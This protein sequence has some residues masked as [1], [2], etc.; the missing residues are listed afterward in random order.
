VSIYVTT[1]VWKFSRSSGSSLLTALAIADF[2]DDDGRA[3]PSIATLARKSRVSERTVQYAL[4][5]LRGLGELEIEANTG[6]KGTNTYI[7]LVDV[8]R[9]GANPAGGAN[10]AGVQNTTAGG[11][12]G[13]TQ[14][15][16]ENRQ[17][18]KPPTP[19]V[20]LRQDGS[21]GLYRLVVPQE[22]FDSYVKAYPGVDVGSEIARAEAWVN[23]NLR[24]RPTSSFGRFL[25]SWLNRAYQDAKERARSPSLRVVGGKATG[26]Q[27]DR[28]RMNAWL[29]G[30]QDNTQPEEQSNVVDV[31]ATEVREG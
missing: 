10:S 13:C 3:Y 7:V 22:V 4:D 14:T 2:A 11:A 28:D 29:F 26:K 16:I 21:S 31:V 17:K 19:K 1:L 12:T 27:A 9:R 5:D 18:K 24:R 15:V 23:D 8:L 25:N 6:P 30:G 20:E